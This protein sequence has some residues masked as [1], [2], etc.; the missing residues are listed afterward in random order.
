M[1]EAGGR[2]VPKKT[3]AARTAVEL[4][5]TIEKKRRKF[6]QKA[7]YVPAGCKRLQ[8]M[9]QKIGPWM[10]REEDADLCRMECWQL[11]IRKDK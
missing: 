8:G 1:Y 4:Y 7:N 10:E 2:F 5:G 3:D 9:R 11:R 6:R